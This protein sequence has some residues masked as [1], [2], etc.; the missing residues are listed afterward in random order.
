MKPKRDR[1]IMMPVYF[2]PA[3]KV[4]LM[5]LSKTT[6][7]PAAVYLREAVD[8]LLKK[9]AKQLKGRLDR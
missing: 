3:Q 6:R 8:M 7:V 9:Y 2:D 5:E 4:A 1:R